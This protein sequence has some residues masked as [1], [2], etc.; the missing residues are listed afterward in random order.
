MNEQ[1]NKSDWTL[2]SSTRE[3]AVHEFGLALEAYKNEAGQF[4]ITVENLNSAE[5]AHKIF[6]TADEYNEY[7]EQFEAEESTGCPNPV[8]V[9]DDLLNE[10]GVELED[11]E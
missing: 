9:L 3:I 7:L 11:A 2:Y 4:A 8:A 1:L 5:L 10:E 6:E